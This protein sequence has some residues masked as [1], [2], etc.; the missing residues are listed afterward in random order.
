MASHLSNA[1]A[2]A[3]PAIVPRPRRGH[4]VRDLGLTAITEYAV[5]VAG[6]A[7][8]SFVSR[9]MGV[10]ALAEYLLV[11]RLIS[12]LQGP[13]QFGM[14]TALARYVAFAGDRE[15]GVRES[16]LLVALVFTL[17]AVTVLG[18]TV[19][20]APSTFSHLFFGR[21]ELKTLILPLT[22]MLLGLSLHACAWGYYRG[23]LVMSI[24]NG[25]EFVNLAVLP[26]VAV[27]VLAHTGSVP[28]LVGTIGSAMALTAASVC[29]PILAGAVGAPGLSM[30]PAM[31]EML[32]YGLPRLAADFGFASLLSV[33]ALAAA[34][35]LS[36]ERVS[37]LLVGLSIVTA[38]ASAI[39]PVGI[40][41]LSK[42]SSMV[43]ENRWSEL[44]NATA[45]MFAVA[46]EISLVG[47]LQLAVFA[48]V[49][50]RSWLGGH[51]GNTVGIVRT[52][53]LSTPFFFIYMAFRGIIDGVHVRAYNT[54][55]I[56][57]SLAVLLSTLAAAVY[58][59]PDPYKG[60]AIA[61]SWVLG[62]ATLGLST[63]QTL[64]RLLAMEIDWRSAAVSCGIAVALAGLSL[65][66]RLATGFSGG[67]LELLAMVAILSI[68]IGIVWFR[69]RSWLVEAYNMY[70]MKGNEQSEA[71]EAV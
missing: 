4:L 51:M 31:G 65:A 19:N 71:S 48:D 70:R 61:F 69:P 7:V 39:A 16:Y 40:V 41:L 24:A 44:R 15:R 37:H 8:I 46:F 43:S 23:R 34:H 18:V 60:F 52:M 42:A 25:L 12:W 57:I 5:M 38:A 22:L 28:L 30:R 3:A 47:G 26:M 68:Y 63:V 58:F 59:S 67:L 1:P 21:P 45:R 2:A 49:L 10:I 62:M 27:L 14:N 13:V 36:V 6:F 29:V 35:F 32:V 11:R 33:P 54:I 66:V 56:L 20:V 64:R 9:R 53:L 17:A 50:I 55:N